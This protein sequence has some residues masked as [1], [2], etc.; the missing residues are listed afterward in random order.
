MSQDARQA[1][2]R[3][4]AKPLA[5]ALVASFK[6]L[7]W[8]WLG[9]WA[10][11]IF[12]Y[13]PATFQGLGAFFRSIPF[14]LPLNLL[15]WLFSFPFGFTSDPLLYGWITA[16]VLFLALLATIFVRSRRGAL[17]ALIVM[18][19]LSVLPVIFIPLGYLFEWIGTGF[20][21]LLNAVDPVAAQPVEFGVQRPFSLTEDIFKSWW[22]VL[23]M[24][25]L[26]SVL[27]PLLWKP[28]RTF[29]GLILA[30][31]LLWGHMFGWVQSEINPRQLVAN[32]PKMQG[33]VAQLL[34]PRIVGRDEQYVEQ[35]VQRII[36]SREPVQ[37][38]RPVSEQ[39]A[40]T[41]RITEQSRQTTKDRFGEMELNG[42]PSIATFQTE[43]T[44]SKDT[45][46]PGEVVTVSG[47]GFRPSTAGRVRWQNSGLNASVQELGTFVSDARGGFSVDVAV[48]TDEERVVSDSTFPNPN[49]IA[50]SQVW[51]FGDIYVTDTFWLVLDRI[52]ETIFQA[53]MGTSFAVLISIPLSFL[54]SQNLMSHNPVSKG[55]YV[56][57]RTI[58]NILRSIEVLIM[59]IIFVASVG[60]GPFAGVLALTLHSIASLGK[61]YSEAIEAIDPGPI[62]AITATGA[63]RLQVIRYAVVPQFIPQFVSFTLYRWD[64]N[65]RMA[66]IIGLVGG[67]GIGDILTQFIG[68]LDWRSAGTA[69]LLIAVVV[70]AMD[71]ASSKIR[72][73]VV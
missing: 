49:T 65:V 56:V 14:N 2:A 27:V 72:A 21:N 15:G 45:V 53:F 3:V 60:I 51:E 70:I 55:V 28:A 71:Y 25:A 7:W 64:I 38:I 10:V 68:L 63:N 13:L 43:V 67:G 18:V 22:L 61:L 16:I 12:P 8:L 47:T 40:L 44:I 5:P 20:A 6:G 36:G 4:E 57:A 59:A 29:A 66:T 31:I 11:V 48:P 39:G 32:A 17:V 50:V 42:D 34:Q 23:T 33:I 37:D 9:L 24:L 62:E 52:I 41:A 26:G 30:G 58:L 19:A 54:A 73:A 69:I 35:S 46:T 1:T